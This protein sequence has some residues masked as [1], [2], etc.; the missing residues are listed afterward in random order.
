ME[1]DVGQERMLCVKMQKSEN[2]TAGKNCGF[3]AAAGAWLESQ[4]T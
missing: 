4:G 2:L 1:E 3:S